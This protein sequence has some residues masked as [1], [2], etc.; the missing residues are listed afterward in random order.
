MRVDVAVELTETILTV[1]VAV[2]IDEFDRVRVGVLC[3][4]GVSLSSCSATDAWSEV[5]RGVVPPE[6]LE[7]RVLLGVGVEVRVA[8]LAALVPCPMV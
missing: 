6:P 5:G 1:G 7:L 8:L 2:A 4:F 3:G